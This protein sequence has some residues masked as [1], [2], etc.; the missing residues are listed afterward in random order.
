VSKTYVTIQGDMWDSI[1]YSQLGDYKFA[2]ALME[3]NT[4]YRNVYVFSAGVR[5]VIPDVETIK[6]NNRL[7]PWKQVRL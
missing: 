6:T 7:P 4:D 5:L 2:D 3:A 1:A